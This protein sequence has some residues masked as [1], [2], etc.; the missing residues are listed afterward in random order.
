MAFIESQVAD[1]FVEK[2]RKKKP[3]VDLVPYAS[4]FYKWFG[5]V[6]EVE[7]TTNN[8]LKIPVRVGDGAAVSYADFDQGAA[9]EGGAPSFKNMLSRPK[10]IQAISQLSLAGMKHTDSQ[11]KAAENLFTFALA[12]HAKRMASTFDSL[13]LSPAGVFATVTTG[14]TGTSLVVSDVRH[15]YEGMP[16]ARYSSNMVTP[17]TSAS[18]KAP[19]VT[20][21]NRLT[22]TITLN[23]GFTGGTPATSDLLLLGGLS[24]ASPST[25][26]SIYDF[27][28]NA[29]TGTVGGLSRA[30]YDQLRSAK[31]SAGSMLNV[32]HG[33][34]SLF[35]LGQKRPEMLDLP[36]EAV[37]I[38]SAGAFAGNA[39][40]VTQRQQI[41]FN[42]KQDNG[43]GAR[44][45]VDYSFNILS[46]GSFAGIPTMLCAHAKDDRIELVIKKNWGKQ[47]T[48]EPQPIDWGNG[49][50]MFPVIDS[51]TYTPKYQYLFGN[52]A[53]FQIYCVDP[54]SE[55]YIDNIALPA[56]W[57]AL[58]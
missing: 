10:Q 12:D 51:V 28:Q 39:I 4:R 5:K 47:V 7:V 2:M 49:G 22:K 15:F 18:G 53:E 32:M 40:D 26:L 3:L 44:A 41:V 20:G 27:H 8:D 1:T 37:W 13:L 33:Y 58:A 45:P 56:G 30:T 48:I 6:A 11:E 35:A 46:D 43:S 34:A 38:G 19:R 16:L 36:K 54:G 42:V 9:G 52:V 24:G 21:V 25:I 29:A 14:T 50:R 23:E 55:A 31:A 17:R 57:S